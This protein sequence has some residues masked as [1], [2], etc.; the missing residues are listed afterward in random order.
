MVVA[1]RSADVDDAA[2]LTQ[3]L[4]EA[5]TWR[6]G[7]PRQTAA[8]VLAVPAFAHYIVGWPRAGDI[9]VVAE[10]DGRAVGAAWCR[11]F[12]DED[13]GYGFV[14]STTPEVSIG[15]VEAFRGNG[16]GGRLLDELSE[17]AYAQ[18]ADTLS[19]SVE[20][21]NPAHHLYER[22]GFVIVS[23]ENGALTMV[24]SLTPPTRR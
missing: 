9:G 24:K 15:V 6:P 10:V 23:C 4:V 2:F 3:M 14:E 13:P 16:V 5:A 1:V 11:Y 17:R 7:S 22:H 12:D 21:E 8:E 18:G 20:T 19:L